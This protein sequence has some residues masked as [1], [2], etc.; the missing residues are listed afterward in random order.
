MTNHDVQILQNLVT[1]LCN[2]LESVAE[3]VSAQTNVLRDIRDQLHEVKLDTRIAG[4]WH[5]IAEQVTFMATH[6]PTTL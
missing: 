6:W 2:S 3:M 1:R 5:T 4:D